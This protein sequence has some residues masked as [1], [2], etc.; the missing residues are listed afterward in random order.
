[1]VCCKRDAIDIFLKCIP[2]GIIKNHGLEHGSA[3]L[4]IWEAF[5]T[6][7]TFRKHYEFAFGIDRT[8]S[9]DNFRKRNMS[10]CM[11]WPTFLDDSERRAL[12]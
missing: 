1:M 3:H 9:S 10:E 12:S 8:G 7:V 4:S 5:A 2:F 11:P 6:P